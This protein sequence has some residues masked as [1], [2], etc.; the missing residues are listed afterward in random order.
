MALFNKNSEPRPTTSMMLII[1]IAVGG[2]LEYLAFSL[3]DS[4]EMPVNSSNLLI[5][6]A[7]VVFLIAGLLFIIFPLRDLLQGRYE[8]GVNDPMAGNKEESDDQLDE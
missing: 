8:G 7:T 1:R 6:I 2:Y 5:V 4:I 3:K